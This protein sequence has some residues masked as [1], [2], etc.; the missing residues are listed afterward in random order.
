VPGFS[1]HP[2]HS[3]V[4]PRLAQRF[5][6]AILE[7]GGN[8]AAIVCRSADLELA[9]HAIA[10]SAIGAAGQRC[11]SL[12]RLFVQ[13]ELYAPLLKRLQQVYLTAR[14]GNPLDDDTILAGPLIDE[15]AFASMQ[16]TLTE[17]RASGAT[18]TGG[19]RCQADVY[20]AAN[21]VRPA[22]VELT[23]QT[24]P[25]LRETFA[26]LLYVMAYTDFEEALALHNGVPQGLASSIF[27]SDVREVEQ[28]LSAEG[29]DCGIAN[30]NIGPS[31]AEIGGAFGGEKETGGGREAGS[32]VWKSYMR[33]V[34]STINFGRELPLAQGVRFQ[35]D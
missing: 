23:K 2:R 8:N 13:N 30:V 31:G 26:P 20:P 27:S 14:V 32:D 7:L 35:V 4:A 16:T 12:R 19:E 33:R 17:L 25:V 3:S 11:T 5:A 18:T 10:F 34:T 9:L 22:L 1:E 29:S 24:G 28:F 21:Y 6:R 15:P